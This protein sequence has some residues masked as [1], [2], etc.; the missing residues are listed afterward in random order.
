MVNITDVY[1]LSLFFFQWMEMFARMKEGLVIAGTASISYSNFQ[2]VVA[3]WD[4]ARPHFRASLVSHHHLI[5]T[6]RKSLEPLPMPP[7]FNNDAETHNAM[8]TTGR[9]SREAMLRQ[10]L[11]IGRKD[12]RNERRAVPGGRCFWDVDHSTLLSVY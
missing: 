6:S 4:G 8:K 12:K 10:R 1:L 7:P 3:V 9:A 5:H 2:V 11:S